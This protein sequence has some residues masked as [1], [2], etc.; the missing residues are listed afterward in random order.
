MVSTTSP[1]VTELPVTASAREDLLEQ[2]FSDELPHWG[3]LFVPDDAFYPTGPVSEQADHMLTA[4]CRWLGVKPG[5]F[6]VEL[7]G[8]AADEKA[9]R[10]RIFVERSAQHNEFLLAAVIAHAL[11]RYLLEDR[12]QIRLPEPDQQAAFCAQ[13][14]VPFGLGIVILNGLIPQFEW[15]GHTARHIEHQLLG[16]LPQ[17]QYVHLVEAFIHRY[18]L[19]VVGYRSSLTPWAARWLHIRTPRR[20]LH[21][22]LAAKH[23]QRLER[24]KLA[25]VAWLS[26]LVAIICAMTFAH[27]ALPTNPQVQAAQD[28]VTLLHNLLQLCQ[29]S[30]AYDQR[31]I[32]TSDIQALRSIQAEQNRCVSLRNQ[33]QSAQADY[34]NLTNH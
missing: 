22:V 27:R 4:L 3:Q 32:D 23:H 15:G 17:V 26:A 9:S 5:Y 11:I 16:T 21:A 29:D 10:Y 6:A 33:Y 1:F 34:A 12:K 20:S 18:R 2:T 25:G 8:H 13:A 7:E 31:Y 14:S 19:P 24:V 30:T 28:Q